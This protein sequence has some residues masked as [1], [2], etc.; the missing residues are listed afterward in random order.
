M[1]SSCCTCVC[2]S[3]ISL[4]AAR[5]GVE[6]LTSTMANNAAAK[7]G[8]RCERVLCMILPK[9]SYQLTVDRAPATVSCKLPTE[10]LCRL[11]KIP[12]HAPLPILV[13][14]WSNRLNERPATRKLSFILDDD[15]FSLRRIGD[16]GLIQ[17]PHQGAAAGGSKLCAHLLK[18]LLPIGLRYFRLEERCCLLPTLSIVAAV[19]QRQPGSRTQLRGFS[20]CRLIMRKRNGAQQQRQHCNG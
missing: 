16:I 2:S 7:R 9:E 4:D 6:R 5:A 1:S 8:L 12:R 15:V 14:Y 11:D 18:R 19:H 10:L 3:V 17:R 13:E 20:F